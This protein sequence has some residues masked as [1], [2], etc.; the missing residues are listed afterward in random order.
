VYKRQNQTTASFL[1]TAYDPDGYIVS[2]SWIKTVGAF[3]DIVNTPFE[4]ATTLENLTED[5]YTY[6]I[7]VQDNDGATATDTINVIRIKDYTVNLVLISETVT[8][9]VNA[10]GKRSKKYQLVL[11]PNI[12]PNDSLALYGMFEGLVNMAGSKISMYASAGYIVEKNGVIIESSNSL[13]N[14]QSIP[15][16]LNYIASD[17]IYI[18]LNATGATDAGTVNDYSHVKSTIKLNS[19]LVTNGVMNIS[20]LPLQEESYMTTT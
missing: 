3:G 2:Q 5:F 10:V 6:Q 15:I 12:M 9:V 7:Q 8:Q 20:G 16:T 18:T 1:A 14:S 11:S 17:V 13:G 19:V 4:L